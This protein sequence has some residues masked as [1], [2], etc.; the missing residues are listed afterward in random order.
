M[1]ASTLPAELRDVL[2]AL[3]LALVGV[4][5]QGRIVFANREAETLL[6]YD[7]DELLEA[8]VEQLVPEALRMRHAACRA[9]YHVAPTTRTMAESRE[10][11][12]QRR[13]G[14]PLPVA[15]SLKSLPAAQSVLTL[16]C[17]IDLSLQ[18]ALETEL[19][20]Q[21]ALMEQRVAERTAQLQERTHQMALLLRSLQ[22]VRAEL[23]RQ[24]R[25][26]PLTGLLNRR[27]FDERA[28]HELRRASRRSSRTCLA[29]LDLDHFKL[30][31][32]RFGHVVGDRVLCRVAASMQ[33]NLRRD[34]V[35]ARYGGEEFVVL[36]P[37]TALEDAAAVIERVRE[38]VASEP[39]H[40]LQRGLELTLSGGAVELCGSET[41]ACAIERADGL[42]YSAKHA[43]RNRIHVETHRSAPVC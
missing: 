14:T 32:D 29:M 17:I 41:L 23:E 10:L 19:R 1:I 31:N 6:G 5:G 42:L 30:V 21:Y 12:A 3:P 11:S 27:E 38:A 26:D 39:W 36:L 7:H 15:I 35:L 22:E 43:G 9:A 33:A 2:E 25:H 8:P 13:D 18:K 37:E 28:A 24:S 20:D 40:E 16:A 34:D 4:D